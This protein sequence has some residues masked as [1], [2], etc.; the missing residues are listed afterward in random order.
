MSP[1][2]PTSGRLPSTA[3]AL[4]AI[5]GVGALAA[6]VAAIAAHAGGRVPAAAGFGTVLVFVIMTGAIARRLGIALPG[7]GFSSYIV[8]VALFAILLR[9][10][11]F[12]AIVA[13]LGLL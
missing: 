10:W 7:Q 1:P 4:R 8:G 2:Q 5:V 12:A 9:G 6:F 11:A 13:P 3:L